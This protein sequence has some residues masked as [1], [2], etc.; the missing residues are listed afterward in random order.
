MKPPK[1]MDTLLISKMTGK[2]EA[3]SRTLNREDRIAQN[4]GNCKL[5]KS[6]SGI[7]GGINIAGCGSL[8]AIPKG[9][10]IFCELVLFA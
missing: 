5:R 3:I 2:V 7:P 10:G 4:F 6:Q 1:D 8:R 9:L